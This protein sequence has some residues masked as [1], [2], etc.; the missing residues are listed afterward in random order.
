M[1]TLENQL[2]LH[3]LEAA[4]DEAKKGLSE[5]GLPI[6]SVLID[7]HSG[8]QGRIV[9]AGHNMRVQTG[10]PTAHAEMVCIKNAGRRRD[11]HKLVLV[12]TLSPCEMCTGTAILY[13]I[14]RIIVGENVNYKSPGEKWLLETR[15]KTQ[16]HLLQNPAC[17]QMMTHFIETQPDLWQEDIHELQ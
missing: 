3:W 4:I 10:D 8:P 11:W 17:I 13:K 2:Y 9:S 5:G 12:S 15:P 16:V 7:P 6:G 1:A 14:P